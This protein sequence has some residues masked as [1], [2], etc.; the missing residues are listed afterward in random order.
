MCELC[1]AN[2]HQFC[3]P[4]STSAPGTTVPS[5][6]TSY[7]VS[8]S[9]TQQSNMQALVAGFKWDNYGVRFSFP[10][11]VTDYGPNTSAYGSGEL[12]SNFAT[13]NDAQKTAARAAFAMI[14]SYS[15]L[16]LTEITTHATAEIRLARSNAPSTAWAYYP[17][18]EEGGD[19]WFNTDASWYTNPRQGTYAWHTMMHEIGHAIGLKHG[20]ETTPNGALAANVDHMEYSVMTYRSY[21][22][23]STANYTNETYG[24]A[25]TFMPYDIAAI[26]AL[27]GVDWGTNNT[28]TTYSFSTSTGEMFVDGV[29]QG[30]PGSNRI[31]QTI[32]D[33]NGSDTIDLSNYN[34]GI[35]A[36]LAPGGS[37]D[38]STTQKAQLGA[39]IWADANLYL[40]FAPDNRKKAMIENIVAGKGDDFIFG[41]STVNMID[42]KGG[43]DT[44][45][46]FGG[47]DTIF[48]GGGRDDIKGG[49]E[50]DIIDGGI[51]KDT[52]SG[53]G[54]A[55]TFMLHDRSAKD[56][57]RD[58]EIGIDIIDV[59]DTTLATLRTSN[60]GHLTVDYLGNWMILRGL[61]L[62]DATIDQLVV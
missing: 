58:F 11:S 54:G 14:E 10:T 34:A 39:G 52:V 53:S 62:G 51:G 49:A 43:S 41:N 40:A 37:I 17:D 44:I 30:R 4:T 8:F 26:Q 60:T 9:G 55:D 25:Q 12:A 19:I 22:G 1:H 32:W 46:A 20:H 28:D 13:F 33:G 6:V 2:G 59:P 27:Y 16:N 3:V 36:N 56:V 50:N 24:Y 29:G 47:N 57:I 21:Q 7:E 23:A 18:T 38:F 5:N 42:A 48:G 35:T 31:F 15:K 61:N 45:E